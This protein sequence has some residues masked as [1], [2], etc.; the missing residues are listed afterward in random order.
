LLWTLLLLFGPATG[1]DAPARDRGDRGLYFQSEPSSSH[2]LYWPGL[3]H[4][5]FGSL[6]VRGRRAGLRAVSTGESQTANTLGGHV[7][8]DRLAA[9]VTG[10][11]EQESV[12]G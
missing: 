6:P 12:L 5:D 9:L 4:Q 1:E 7:H 8:A 11:L 10:E 3:N 2:L